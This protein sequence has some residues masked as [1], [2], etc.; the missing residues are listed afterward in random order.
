M[1]FDFDQNYKKVSEIYAM[2]KNGE[3]IVDNSYQ[4]KSVWGGRDQVRLVETILLNLVVPSVYFWNSETDPDN[5]H[6]ITHIVDGQQRLTAIRKF[7]TNNL[8]LSKNFLLDNEMKEKYG[9]KSF[10]Q[11]DPEIKKDF[12]DYKL[13]VIEIAREVKIADIKE[14][15]KRLNLTD[16]NLNSQEKR[17]AIEGDFDALAKELAEQNLWSEHELFKA[18]I[19]K[20][21]KDIEFCAD[22]IILYK[23]GIVD[24]TTDK[25]L[26]EAYNDYAVSYEEAENDKEAIINAMGII[27]KLINDNTITFMRRTSQLYSMFSFAFYVLRENKVIDQKLIVRFSNFV[28]LYANYKNEDNTTLDLDA[29]ERKL[30]DQIKKYKQASSEGV[31]KQVNR[32]TRYEVLKKILLTSDF[33]DELIQ[34]LNDKLKSSK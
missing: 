21:M 2:Q 27:N 25:V 19:I 33:S 7:V 5:G 30:Y 9:N 14:M 4:R 31:R 22:L 8:V 10:S 16:Y 20:R 29:E 15:F 24:Q 17:N 12:W 11:L 18:N 26:N 13:S 34:Q 32:M 6:T 1:K 23:R 28:D 3:L